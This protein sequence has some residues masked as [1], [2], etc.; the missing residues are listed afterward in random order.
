MV[1]S[2]L[3]CLLYR[4]HKNNK[5]G[6]INAEPFGKKAEIEPKPSASGGRKDRM[7]SKPRKLPP[8]ELDGV[9][10]RMIL[11]TKD[12]EPDGWPAVRMKDITRLLNG[13]HFYRSRVELLAKHQLT[14]RDP[15]RTLVCDIIAN[16]QLLPDTDGKRYGYPPNK[17]LSGK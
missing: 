4:Q 1:M 2:I 14:M 9:V 17:D 3:R 13:L 5:V 10:G 15:E 6:C 8:V 7:K 11:L 16:G 12:H